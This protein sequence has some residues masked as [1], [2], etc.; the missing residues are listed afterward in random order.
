MD[1]HLKNDTLKVFSTKSFKNNV[2]S[3]LIDI[4][5]NDKKIPLHIFITILFSKW[6]NKS[7][8]LPP[9]ILTKKY[10]PLFCVC[11]HLHIMEL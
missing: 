1:L 7:C 5:N 6:Y 10:S 9:G 3:I 11:L 8:Q 2:S 4:Q